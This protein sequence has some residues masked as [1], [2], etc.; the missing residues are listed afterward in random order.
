MILNNM[1]N[2]LKNIAIVNGYTTASYMLE[3]FPYVA[4]N[5]TEHK[6]MW[7]GAGTTSSA[8]TSGVLT[9]P[10]VA[11]SSGIVTSHTGT[12][13]YGS[14]YMGFGKGLTPVSADDY[15]LAELIVEGLEILN[16]TATQTHTFSEDGNSMVRVANCTFT[17]SNTSTEDITITEIGFFQAYCL[18]TTNAVNTT[19]DI[20]VLMH[21]EVLETPITIGAGAGANLNFTF[22]FTTGIV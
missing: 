9:R 6:K 8:R 3:M 22:T 7:A 13:T 15:K 2:I 21:R 16:L 17:L 5:G 10:L 20:P 11:F 12:K 4:A 14:T 18:S 1:K 19:K